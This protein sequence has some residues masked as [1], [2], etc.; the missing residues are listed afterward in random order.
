MIQPVI[1]YGGFLMHGGV[2]RKSYLLTTQEVSNNSNTHLLLVSFQPLIEQ[3]HP[4]VPER[5]P[6]GRLTSVFGSSPSGRRR[7]TDLKK[8]AKDEDEYCRVTLQ[9]HILPDTYSILY[10]QKDQN[11]P[12]HSN[13]DSPK[14]IIT[15]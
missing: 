1:N 4:S 12:V 11:V 10:M 14:I 5:H 7:H 6:V 9:R 2:K 15:K 8:K 13:H 3:T